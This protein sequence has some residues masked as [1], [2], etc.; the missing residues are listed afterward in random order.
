M[1]FR[2]KSA[3]ISVLSMSGIYGFYFWSVIRSGPHA[4]GFHFGGLLETV[5]ALV[6][7]EIVLTVSVAIFTPKEAKAPRDERDKLIELRAM[8]VAYSGLATSVAIACFFAGFTPPL[9][10]NANALLFI[11]VTAEILRSACQIVQYRRGA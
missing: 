9:L 8:R 6:V 1:S 11:L 2:E 4:S 7:V 10:F 3:W 5:I